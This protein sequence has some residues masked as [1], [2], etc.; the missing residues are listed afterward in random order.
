MIIS[1][2]KSTEQIIKHEI[3][4]LSTNKDEYSIIIKSVKTV[5]SATISTS[6]L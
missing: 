1:K 3:R 6:K 2:I 4:A 5:K